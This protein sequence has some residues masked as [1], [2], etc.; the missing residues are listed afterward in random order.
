MTWL[1]SLWAGVAV[2]GFAMVFAVPR[3]TLPTIVTI[4]VLA[5]LVRSIGLELGATLPAAS[6]VAALLVGFT[7][8]LLAPRQRQAVPIYAFAPVIPLIPGTYMFQTLSGLLDL[9]SG[10]TSQTSAIV[11]VVIV[12]AS[13]ATL[14]I[15][16]L[17]VGAIS[18][19]LL[20]GRHLARLGSARGSSRAQG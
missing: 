18:P 8:A 14:T 9:T 10:R 20:V 5:H 7:A 1:M 16:A 3:T 13:I 6:L 15:I 19:T 4:A 17:A 11:E 12:D 2:L